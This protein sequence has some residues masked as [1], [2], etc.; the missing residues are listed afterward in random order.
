MKKIKLGALHLHK[1][2]PV[3]VI[4]GE[5]RWNPSHTTQIIIFWLSVH[6]H[7]IFGMRSITEHAK[8]KK[9]RHTEGIVRLTFLPLLFTGWVHIHWSVYRLHIFNKRYTLSWVHR[10]LYILDVCPV[11][12]NCSLYG[13]DYVLYIDA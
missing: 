11:F 1:Q 5:V 2:N 7:L 12:P 3:Q 10:K 6:I 8:R 4:I 13:Y 9:T